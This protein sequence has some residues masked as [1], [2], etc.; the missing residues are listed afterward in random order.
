M[1]RYRIRY[2]EPESGGTLT[3]L[4]IGA[5]AGFAVGMLVA[6]KSGGIAGITARVKDRWAELEESAEA[7]LEPTNLE[8]SHES[9]FG[10]E[11]E[12]EEEEEVEDDEALEDEDLDD[13]EDDLHAALEDDVLEA[14]QADATLRERAIDISAVGDGLIELSGWVDSDDESHHAAAVARRVEGVESVV[15]RLA[16]GQAD[17]PEPASDETREHGAMRRRPTDIDTTRDE[18]E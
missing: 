18:Q 3:S 4:V 11:L 14:F 17:S 7:E 6:Q 8:A 15:N 10:E 5:V 16:V 13:D 2:E 12:E 9:D 1:S